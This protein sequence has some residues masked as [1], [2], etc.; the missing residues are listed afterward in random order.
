MRAALAQA[1]GEQP[2]AAFACTLLAVHAAASGSR[3]LQVGDGAV[4]LREA[5]GAWRLALPPQR[6]EFANE[7][8]FVT[9]P[10]AGASLRVVNLPE[11][12]AEF[13]L[14]SDGVEFLAIRQATLEP[15]GAFFDHVFAGMREDDGAGER[16]DQAAWLAAFLGSPDADARTDDDRTLVIAVRS[17]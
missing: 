3:V 12:P 7:T 15:H 16:P 9:S 8:V 4:V 14:M 1:A 11:P 6:G 5:S 2:L 10:E 17:A 13:A